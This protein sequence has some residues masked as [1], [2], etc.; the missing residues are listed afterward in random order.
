MNYIYGT[1]P[2][3]ENPYTRKT[4][5]IKRI[6]DIRAIWQNQK[7]SSDIQYPFSV[8]RESLQYYKKRLKATELFI[9]TIEQSFIF[10]RELD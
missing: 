6:D 5:L 9:S 3:S 2:L 8:L 4:Q 1:E 10:F 7:F